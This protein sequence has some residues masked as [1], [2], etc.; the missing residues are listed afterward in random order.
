MI[1]LVISTTMAKS[2]VSVKQLEVIL[3]TEV[4]PILSEIMLKTVEKFETQIGIPLRESRRSKFEQNL[5]NIYGELFTAIG[6][7]GS[8]H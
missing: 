1:P 4:S 5:K 3:S 8:M 2:A 7:R 6:T